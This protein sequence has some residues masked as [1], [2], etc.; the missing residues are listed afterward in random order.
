MELPDDVPL[1]YRST[2]VRDR[3][4][5]LAERGALYRE[6]LWNIATGQCKYPEEVAQ[7]ALQ[8]TGV[9]IEIGACYWSRR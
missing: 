3:W 2:S 5:E 1:L 6:V 8:V 7:A 4:Q 9:D